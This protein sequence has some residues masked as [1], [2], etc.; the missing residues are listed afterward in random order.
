MSSRSKILMFLGSRSR[1]VP[2]AD[3]FTA[4]WPDYPDKV[5]FL[6][7]HKPLGL[8]GLLRGS[9]YICTV[10]IFTMVYVLKFCIQVSGHAVRLEMKLADARIWFC[11]LRFFCALLPPLWSSGQSSWLQF[12][13]SGF[14]SRRCQN[15]W[16]VVGLERG[17]LR[18]MSTS[19]KLLERKVAASV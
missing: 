18:L 12:E 3:F 5:G 17:P 14:D 19:E 9:L 6:K 7:S 8:H 4:I 1:L 10:C 11:A 2:R 15:F 13:R 16:E